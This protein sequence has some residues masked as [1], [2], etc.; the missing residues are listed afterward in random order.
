M[1][2]CDRAVISATPASEVMKIIKANVAL[3]AQACPP[4]RVQPNQ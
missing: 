1:G 2:Y 4:A 3:G